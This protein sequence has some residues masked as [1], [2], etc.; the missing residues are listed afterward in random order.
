MKVNSI[1]IAILFLSPSVS[2][3]QSGMRVMFYNV[4]NFFDC[5]DDSLKK[6][7]EFLPEGIRGWTP[8]R[9]Y[10]K[11]GKIAKVIASAG[12]ENGFPS[13]V[14]LAEVENDNC[15]KRLTKYSPLKNA[16]Y[17]YVHY[18]SPDIRGVDVCLLYNPYVFKILSGRPYG[19]SFKEAP[20]RKTRDLLYVCG[21]Y[22]TGDTIHIIIC[23]FPS[24][25]EGEK[26]TEPY[27]CTV[28]LAVKNI[29]D[30]V[31]CIDSNANIIV[32]G[33]F[34]EDPEGKA[35]CRVLN[36]KSRDEITAGD[37]LCNLMKSFPANSGKGSHKNKT[38]WSMLDQ[39]IVSRNLISKVTNVS[40][41]SPE[42]LLVPDRRWLG[43]KPFRTFHG[44]R[45]QGG[46][47]DHL[48]VFMDLFF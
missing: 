12:G 46:F 14:G 28:A 44:M 19:I 24:M 23:H 32:M 21:R 47:S 10:E 48:P 17:S 8:A 41:F 39:I 5:E 16:G 26:E 30:S 37:R 43:M 33:D 3:S 22:Y 27:R 25:L 6:D 45:Y 11:T 4:E 1:V 29:T 40:I 31:F 13:L 38:E 20:E 9:F 42:Y 34:N 15:L 35:L 36:A 2:L 18:E 7:E